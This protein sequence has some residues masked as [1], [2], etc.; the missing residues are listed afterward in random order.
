MFFVSYLGHTH[1][2][3]MCDTSFMQQCKYMFQATI[4]RKIQL[5]KTN[6]EHDV[7][8]KDLRQCI[9]EQAPDMNVATLDLI[10]AMAENS[11]VSPT[12]RRWDRGVLR[13]ALELYNR[14]P[15]AYMDT[16]NSGYMLLPSV[17]VLR[18]YKNVVQQSPGFNQ[19]ALAWMDKAAQEK[20]VPEFGRH[21]GLI[22][23]E[24]AIQ[25]DLQLDSHEG[26]SSLVGAVD[27]G[28][29]CKDMDILRH[30]EQKTRLAN[31]VLQFE[32]LGH[33]GFVFP[34]AH[35]PTTGVQAYH[36]LVIFWEAVHHLLDF[37]FH[38][39]F[40]L[41]DGAVA[42]RT[43]LKSLFIPD[44][45]IA[46]R[47]TIPNMEVPGKSIVMG[48]EPKHVIKRLRNNVYSSGREEEHTRHL[49]RGEHHIVWDHWQ[50]AYNWDIHSNPEMMRYAIKRS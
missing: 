43:F 33:T 10:C 50:Q 1:L 49:K 48:M 37:D 28:E 38:V 2:G 9:K 44:N 16:T 6:T 40:C 12:G 45:P 35:F 39:D 22:F 24:M 23:D 31:H 26:R 46:K 20:K 13:F 47:M 5:V 30:G 3:H 21:G 15:Q 32:F 14:S 17:R 42:N 25:E 29:E 18:L 19:E 36:L 11:S 34:F 4:A 41:F 7:N 27:L 8:Q